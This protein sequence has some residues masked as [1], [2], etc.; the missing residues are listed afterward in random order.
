MLSSSIAS[1][2]RRLVM[3]GV[4]PRNSCLLASR[5]LISSTRIARKEDTDNPF[6]KPGP[7]PLPPKEQREFEQLVKENAN[8]LQFKKSTESDDLHP[9]YRAK[10]KADF[11]GDVNPKTGEVG[12]PKKE[13]LTWEREWT[14]GGRCSDF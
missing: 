6:I 9:Q 12:G 2:S 1:T 11:E 3:N 7:I 14:Y 13:P 10:P 5:R 8:A 4:V